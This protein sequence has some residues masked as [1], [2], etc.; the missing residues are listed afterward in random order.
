MVNLIPNSVCACTAFIFTPVSP[1]LPVFKD[2]LPLAVSS[3]FHYLSRNVHILPH[4]CAATIFSPI[5]SSYPVITYFLRNKINK[6]KEFNKTDGPEKIFALDIAQ[7][8]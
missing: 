3:F 8:I 4:N 5:I 7:R 2:C 1:L 6:I